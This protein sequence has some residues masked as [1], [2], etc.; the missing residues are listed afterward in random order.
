[1]VSLQT[2]TATGTYNY[3]EFAAIKH[4]QYVKSKNINSPNRR[5]HIINNYA[6]YFLTEGKQCATLFTSGMLN[7]SVDQEWSL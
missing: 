1:M 4:E 5:F 2:I 7:E 6:A 3:G